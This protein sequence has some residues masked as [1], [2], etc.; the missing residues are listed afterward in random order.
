VIGEYYYDAKSY[1]NKRHYVFNS[2]F[3]LDRLSSA[4]K[5]LSVRSDQGVYNDLL[6]M[7]R[8]AFKRISENQMMHFEASTSEILNERALKELWHNVKIRDYAGALRYCTRLDEKM[9]ALKPDYYAMLR[10]Q[11]GPYASK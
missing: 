2:R 5:V 11:M 9:E 3:F 8:D 10:E 6:Q 1:K 4:L 7:I